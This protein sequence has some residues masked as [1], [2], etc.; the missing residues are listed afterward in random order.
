MI[1]RKTFTSLLIIS[2]L[3]SGR[4]IWIDEEMSLDEYKSLDECDEDCTSDTK[5]VC[6]E[7]HNVHRCYAQCKT[8]HNIVHY[9]FKY[10]HSIK[11]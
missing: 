2:T 10:L 11:N 9:L 1:D 8:K 5:I 3:V 7:G 4:W 6:Y